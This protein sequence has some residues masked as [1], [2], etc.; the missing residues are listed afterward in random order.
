MPAPGHRPPLAQ[1]PRDFR[2]N[3][4][5]LRWTR[6]LPHLVLTALAVL[7]GA[8]FWEDGKIRQAAP[9]LLVVALLVLPLLLWMHRLFARLLAGQREAASRFTT[10]TPWACQLEN[11]RYADTSG[12]VFLVRE[13]HASVDSPRFAA[14][15]R[16]SRRVWNL[17]EQATVDIFLDPA[18]VSPVFA[19]AAPNFSG[20]G[21]MLTRQRLDAGWRHTRQLL[22]WLMALVLLGC[23]MAG[24][25]LMQEYESLSQTRQRAEES[26]AW[27]DTLGRVLESAVAETRIPSGK[28]SVPGWETIILY[29]Y[30]VNGV[31]HSGQ[32]IRHGYGPSTD[33]EEALA[34]AEAHPPGQEVRVYYDPHMPA[35]AVLQPGHAEPL[36]AELD[37]IRLAALAGSAGVLVATGIPL[38][39]LW[40]MSR[41]RQRLLLRLEQLGL[42][43]QP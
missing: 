23:A 10:A 17:S 18:G 22:S 37:R 33:R 31:L 42:A 4:A 21:E 5:V 6:V 25:V 3:L 8:G 39:V 15:M 27:P 7:A 32:R 36:Q 26:Q 19:V 41:R 11:T 29:E 40:H 38:G 2:I 1:P 20:W 30:A 43:A 16:F 34:L 9:L 12:Q 28:T 24:W 13:A 35:R 14:H